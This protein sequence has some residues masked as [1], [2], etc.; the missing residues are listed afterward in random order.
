MKKLKLQISAFFKTELGERVKLSFCAMCFL[1]VATNTLI[2][3]YEYDQVSSF[4]DTQRAQ[5]EAARSSPPRYFATLEHI[6]P[7]IQASA[8][9]INPAPAKHIRAP[10]PPNAEAKLENHI[11]IESEPITRSLP[12]GDTAFLAYTPRIRIKKHSNTLDKNK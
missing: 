9:S 12:T 4:R 11:R 8:E 7:I 6:P 3:A 10:L 2:L 5:W 1:A